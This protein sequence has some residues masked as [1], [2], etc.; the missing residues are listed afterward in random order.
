MKNTI[1]HKVSKMFIVLVTITILLCWIINCTFLVQ[2]YYL[3]KKDVLMDAY[4][5]INTANMTESIESQEFYIK[6]EQICGKGN[7]S[8]IVLDEEGQAVFS[9]TNSAELFMLHR[10]ILEYIYGYEDNQNDVENQIL[11]Q[12]ERITIQRRNNTRTKMNYMEMWGRLESGGYFLIRTPVESIRESVNLSNQF[13]M[14]VGIIAIVLSAFVIYGVT[15]R[16]TRP[17]REL[18]RISE[19]MTRLNFEAKYMPNGTIE[20]DELGENMNQLS[21]TLEST[22]SELKAA[23]NE[24][25][26]DIER[27]EKIDEM[28]QEFLANVSHELK[29]PIALI[30]GYAEGLME[31]AFED[32]ESKAFYCE[33]IMDEANKMNHLVKSLLELNQIEFGNEQIAFSR[34]DI[35]EVIDGILTSFKLTCE[36]KEIQLLFEAESPV[37]I[38][39]DEFKIE[40]VFRNFLTNAIHHAAGEKKIEIRVAPWK[41]NNIE[42][43]VFNTG[44]PIPEE[45]ISRIWEKFYKVDKARTREYGGN[46]IGLSIV[47]AIM[48]SMHKPFGVKNFENGVRFWFVLDG[49][50]MEKQL[51]LEGRNDKIETDLGRER[52]VL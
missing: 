24:L 37:Y 18:A 15:K 31:G 22:I 32:E 14:Y 26:S 7:L 43:S 42:I 52:D 33:V 39:G 28:R 13:L 35:V 45:D 5:A 2:F 10:Q 29:T 16:L 11:Y 20:V 6:M 12:N 19:E 8:L 1:S 25:K 27:K 3:D 17:I 50:A 34:M 41:E 40:E 48:D 21:E 51:P 36:Q 46:G 44:E 38:W 23:N 30:Q 47:K 9:T 49:D 4:E